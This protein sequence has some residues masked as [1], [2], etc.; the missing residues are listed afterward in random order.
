MTRTPLDQDCPACAGHGRCR[1]DWVLCAVCEGLGYGYRPGAPGLDCLMTL[2]GR[3]I[4]QVVT[5]GTG[6][7]GRVV[8]HSLVGQRPLTYVRLHDAFTDA[9]DTRPTPFP[10]ACGVSFVT[11]GDWQTRH[12]PRDRGARASSDAIDPMRFR[13]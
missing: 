1:P 13:P 11:P 12:A 9:E 3:P 2:H 4:G 10:T 8:K 7:V 5:L 6:Q